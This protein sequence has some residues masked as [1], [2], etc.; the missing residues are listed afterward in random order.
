MISKEC[1]LYYLSNEY[2]IYTLCSDQMLSDVKNLPFPLPE[3]KKKYIFFLTSLNRKVF[4]T[5]LRSFLY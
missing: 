2:N 4:R 1:L 3:M 5:K